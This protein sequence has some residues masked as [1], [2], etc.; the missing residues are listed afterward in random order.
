M[1]H[2]QGKLIGVPADK[3]HGHYI[4]DEVGQTVCD[5]YFM[6]YGKRFDFENAEGNRRRLVA[7]WNYCQGKTTE[8]LEGDFAQGY[9]PWRH[10]EHLEAERDAFKASEKKVS[11]AYLR[12]RELVNAF[13]TPH[14]PS[15]EQVY[16]LTESKVLAL[17]QTNKELLEALKWLDRW[18]GSKSLLECANKVRAA[19]ARAEGGQQ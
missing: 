1:T 16:D 10:V 4:E 13:D 15:P 17:K 18:M 9:E 8:E 11:D 12:I 5:L 3:T 14:A 7:C 19:I 6:E 2:T